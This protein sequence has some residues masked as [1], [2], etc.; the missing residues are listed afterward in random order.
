MRK[1]GFFLVF[2]LL[3]MAQPVLADDMKDNSVTFDT[4][5]IESD[6]QKET[7]QQS[8]LIKDLFDKETNTTIE[9]AKKA[10][11]KLEEKQNNT[12]FKDKAVNPQK[13]NQ[14]ALFKQQEDNQ[15]QYQKSDDEFLNDNQGMTSSLIYLFL[16][17]LIVV[18]AVALSMKLREK[19]EEYTH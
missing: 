3:F 7:G 2:L 11:R 8:D 10:K 13:V 9:K 18:I 5:R 19:D 6:Q 15:V 4:N 12:L 17:L 14:K 1:K 16:V